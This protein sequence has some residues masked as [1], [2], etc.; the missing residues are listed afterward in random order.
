MSSPKKKMLYLKS[1]KLSGYKTIKNTEVEFKPG[2]NIIIGK[3]AVGKTNLVRFLLQLL[4]FRFQ[5]LDGDFK[6][7]LQISQIGGN[8]LDIEIIQNVQTKQMKVLSTGLMAKFSRPVQEIRIDGELYEPNATEDE[9]TGNESQLNKINFDSILVEHGIPYK[10]LLMEEAFSFQ[11]SNVGRAFKYSEDTR[12]PFFIRSL[13]TSFFLRTDTDNPTPDIVNEKIVAASEKMLAELRGLIAY[14]TPIEDVRLQKELRIEKNEREAI[15]ISNLLLEYRVS[16][17][18]HRFSHLSSGTQRMFYLITE[19]ANGGFFSFQNGRITE[20]VLGGLS[21]IVFLE[22]PELGIH[23]HQL[24]KLMLFLKQQAEDKQIILTTHSPQVLDILGPDELDRIIIAKHDKVK[25]TTMHH[26]SKPQIAKAKK[27][28]KE[29]FLSDY[30][31]FS[32]LEE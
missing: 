11:V 1:A 9:D 15:D 10:A 8:L 23:P 32:D 27:Y 24:H 19:V 4:Q 17:R 25:G 29:D 13:I 21:H 16:G 22:E 7:S 31:R 2:L 26:L 6:S 30:W 5:E 3:N 14:L 20:S 28:M 18:W 12:I